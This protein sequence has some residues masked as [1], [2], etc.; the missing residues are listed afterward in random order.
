VMDWSY[1]GGNLSGTVRN[2]G[3]L[4]LYNNQVVVAS[5]EQCAWQEAALDSATLQPGEQT[6]FHLSHYSAACASGDLLIVG[7]GVY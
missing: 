6:S 3:S 4:A 2:G 1:Q 5:R 7:Q